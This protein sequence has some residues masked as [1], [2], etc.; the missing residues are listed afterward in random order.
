M[1]KTKLGDFEIMHFHVT[2][3]L[4]LNITYL[5]LTAKISLNKKNARDHCYFTREHL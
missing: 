2:I 3:V 4:Y 5:A 1:C